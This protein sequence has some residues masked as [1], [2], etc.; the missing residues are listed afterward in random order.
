MQLTRYDPVREW[1]KMERDLN[2]FW[3]N[4]WGILP[5]MRVDVPIDIY[6]E[7]NKLIAEI[8]LPNF[9]KDEVAVS[10]EYGALE[11]SANHEENE[12]DQDKR[13]YLFRETTNQYYRRITLPGNIKEE[14]AD[15]SFKDGLLKITM[16][17]DNSKKKSRLL[18]IK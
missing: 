6:E 10:I 12:E 16:E 17:I 4:D 2:K 18:S 8:S 1:R 9:D 15:A 7:G 14:K 3:N 5:S 11:V 13:Q